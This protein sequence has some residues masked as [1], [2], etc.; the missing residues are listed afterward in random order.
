[1]QVDFICVCG[2]EPKAHNDMLPGPPFKIMYLVWKDVWCVECNK[3][4]IP[5][6]IGKHNPEHKFKPDTLKYL[7]NKYEQRFK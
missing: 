2:H 4:A 6:Q 1:M 7:Q 3:Y 5:D